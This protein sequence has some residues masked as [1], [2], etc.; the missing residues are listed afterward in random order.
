MVQLKQ[1]QFAANTAIFEEGE[2]GDAAYI[3]LSGRVTI[4]KGM[5]PDNPQTLAELG[6]GEVFGEMALFDN[7]PRMASAVALTDIKVIKM[8]K[9]DFLERLST[10]DPAIKNMVLSMVVRVRSMADEFMLQKT[11]VGWANGEKSE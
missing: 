4:H 8:S 3:I 2:E 6:E 11:G 9:E 1:T 10:M 7:R 5:Q